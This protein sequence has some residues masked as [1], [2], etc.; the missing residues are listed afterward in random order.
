MEEPLL[1]ERSDRFVLFPIED[2]DVSVLPE[3]FFLYTRLVHKTDTQPHFPSPKSDTT[4]AQRYGKCI[5]KRKL[6]SGLL[7]K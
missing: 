6:A 7:K 3:M 4:N 1:K 2:D 5:N